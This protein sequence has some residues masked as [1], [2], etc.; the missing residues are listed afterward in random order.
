MINGYPSYTVI[1]SDD[2]QTGRM[3]A[4]RDWRPVLSYTVESWVQEKRPEFILR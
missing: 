4:P 2:M 3:L 1:C